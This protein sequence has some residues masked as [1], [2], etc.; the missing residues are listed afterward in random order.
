MGRLAVWL[1]GERGMRKPS[2]KG[3]GGNK[4]VQAILIALETVGR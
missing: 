3:K 4:R 2:R 1:L